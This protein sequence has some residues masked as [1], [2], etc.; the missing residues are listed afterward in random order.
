MKLRKLPVY[1]LTLCGLFVSFFGDIVNGLL[2]KIL[3]PF[4]F[5]MVKVFIYWCLW[6]ECKDKEDKFL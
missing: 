4:I 2:N 6:M 3:A 1:T 5:F